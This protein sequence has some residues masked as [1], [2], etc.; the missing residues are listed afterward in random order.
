LWL[1]RIK[2]AYGQRDL[3]ANMESRA[4]Y[5]THLPRVQAFLRS[6]DPIGI[7]SVDDVPESARDEYDSYAPRV[8]SILM[9][10]GGAADIAEFLEAIRT[11]NIG[12][13]PDGPRDDALANAIVAWWKSLDG[14]AA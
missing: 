1:K 3:E 12:L 9:R 4:Y 13:P 8:L 14:P 2:R 6:W 11:E 10:R 5:N 7:L